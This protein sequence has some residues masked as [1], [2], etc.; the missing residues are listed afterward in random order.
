MQITGTILTGGQS[1]RMGS[2]KALLQLEGK[3]LLK[4][5]VDL[6][7]GLCEEILI[8]SNNPTHRI[9]NLRRIEDEV[10]DCGPIGG[11]YTCLKHS[12]NDWNFVLSVDAPFVQPDFI[13]FLKNKTDQFDAIVPVHDGKK[14][15]LIAMYHKNALPQIEAQIKAENYKLHFL[16]QELNTNFVDATEWLVRYPELFRN[17]NAPEDLLY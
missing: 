16:L 14:E 3:T 4:R 17:L 2:D 15:P 5:A 13:Q 8:S 7:S 10:A 9:E 11:I 12:A 6:C 1:K